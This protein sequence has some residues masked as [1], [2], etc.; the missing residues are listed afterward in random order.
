[1]CSGYRGGRGGEMREC[2]PQR[3]PEIFAAPSGM[4]FTQLSPESISDARKR[5]QL[6]QQQYEMDPRGPMT[7]D[8][9][10]LGFDPDIGAV[11]K[12][13]H[14]ARKLEQQTFDRG[15]K[16][17]MQSA[18]Q[19]AGDQA[20]E[21]K[22]LREQLTQQTKLLTHMLQGIEMMGKNLMLETSERRKL[23]QRFLLPP[24]AATSTASSAA[25]TKYPDYSVVGGPLD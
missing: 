7:S 2:S 11:H 24:P 23:E 15:F 22:L 12:Q 21:T 14:R 6:L 8:P 3:R 16:E 25:Y 20:Q 1:M 4:D 18:M 19:N 9:A 5:N 10:D 13:H 17:F